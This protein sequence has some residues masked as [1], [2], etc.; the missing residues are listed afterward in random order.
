MAH[1]LSLR[2][3]L[4][5]LIVAARLVLPPLAP[6]AQPAEPRP[7][8]DELER[9]CKDV[10]PGEGRILKC[11]QEHDRD[12]SAGCRDKVQSVLKRLEEAK[13]ACAPDIA[14]FCADVVPGGGRLIRC[15]EPHAGELTPACREKTESI[16]KQVRKAK[17][18]VSYRRMPLDPGSPACSPKG[19][20]G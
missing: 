6:A 5:P 14:R 15:L 16:L 17:K 18:P 10:Q 19:D 9:F 1:P 3:Y 11:L 20:E 2:S 12:L 7:C 8:M 13:Q 4:L